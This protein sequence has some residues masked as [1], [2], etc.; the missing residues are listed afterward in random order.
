V[1]EVL[2][3]ENWDSDIDLEWGKPWSY[4]D[5][6]VAEYLILDP[7]DSFLGGARG[8]GWRLEAGRYVPWQPDAAGRWVSRLGFAIG[9]EGAWAIV[10]GVDGQRIPREGR[11]LRGLAEREAQGRVVMARTMVQRLLARRFH[12]VPA[13][14]VARLERIE[15]Q[16]LLEDLADV[17]LDVPDLDAFMAQLPPATA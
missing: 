7:G 6:G 13:A 17:A 16:A 3:P 14:M 11:I 5:A 9:Y 4:A 12:A 1:V 15:D 10:D 2:S 8:R